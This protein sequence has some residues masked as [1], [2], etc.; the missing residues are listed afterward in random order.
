MGCRETPKL[1][2]LKPGYR[3]RI[4]SDDQLEEFRAATLEFLEAAGVHCPSG[5]ALD[6]YAEGGADVDF[7]T[8]IVSQPAPRGGYRD[9]IA[10][11]R[12]KTRWTLENYHPQPLTGEQKAELRSILRAAEREFG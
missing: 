12:E 5:R 11:A 10:V 4:L 7:E 6:I 1:Q 3:V 8:E 9:P 2:P